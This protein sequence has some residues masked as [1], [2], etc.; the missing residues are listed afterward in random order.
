MRATSEPASGS[1]TARAPIL[2]PARAGRLNMRSLYARPIIHAVPHERTLRPRGNPMTRAARLFAAWSFLALAAAC[3]KPGVP[4]VGEKEV[5]L[6]MSAPLSGPA[7]AWGSVHRGAQAWAAHVNA[8]GGVNGRQIR[9]VI[10]DDGYVPGR[11]VVNVTEMKDSV[12]A[13]VGLLGTAVLN[14][15]KDLVAEAGVPVGGPFGH[16]RVFARQPK[17][18]TARAFAL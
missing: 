17:A 9:V 3:A 13:I 18:K 2:A 1:V 6:G 10:K 14:A 4:G 7:A 15:N 12:F 16:P 5:V 8:N 11:A